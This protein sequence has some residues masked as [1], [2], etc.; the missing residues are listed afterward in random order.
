MKCPQCQ[1]Q[2]IHFLRWIQKYNAFKTACLNCGTPLKANIFVYLGFAVTLLA[3]LV[4]IPYLDVFF[5][6]FGI[7]PEY[8]KLKLLALFPVVL[9]GGSLTWLIGG[10]KT[11]R[12]T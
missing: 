12:K 8:K 2:A 1:S 4:L 3:A 6:F 10:Y 11:G 7:E 9:L 5:S